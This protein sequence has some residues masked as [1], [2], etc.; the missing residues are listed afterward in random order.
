MLKKEDVII[1]GGNSSEEDDNHGQ[2][3]LKKFDTLVAADC[4][5]NNEEECME[6]HDPFELTEVIRP[7]MCAQ[8]LA[9]VSCISDLGSIL[10]R[11]NLLPLREFFSTHFFTNSWLCNNKI[12]DGFMGCFDT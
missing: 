8:F 11:F 3:D 1:G 5:E 10:P 4:L 2:P 7:N 9:F 6:T 12:S